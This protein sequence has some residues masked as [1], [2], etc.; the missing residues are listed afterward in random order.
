MGGAGGWT[1]RWARPARLLLGVGFSNCVETE[2]PRGLRAQTGCSQMYP[3]DGLCAIVVRTG[4]A[5]ASAC[6]SL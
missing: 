4:I 2:Y 1:D 6:V 5:G 3:R